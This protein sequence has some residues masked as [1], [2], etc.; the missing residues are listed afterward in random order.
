MRARS[1]LLC[2]ALLLPAPLAAQA[3]VAS[4]EPVRLRA[5]GLDGVFTFV[6]MDGDS[7]TVRGRDD[8][9]PVVVPL[10]SVR[11]LSV[12][13]GRTPTGRSALR[14]AGYGLLIG[15]GA[16]VVIGFASGD[17]T[18]DCFICLSAEEKA[19]LAGGVLGVGG[20]V[21]GGVAGALTRPHR[22]VDVPLTGDASTTVS[23]AP[24]GGGVAVGVRLAH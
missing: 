12:A 15:G 14:G 16:G 22:W 21:V 23:V 18:G 10:A 2:A 1:L 6:A 11:S 8:G 5:A 20:A 13:R 7:L 19:L 24:S 17:E 3:P 4:G 9:V